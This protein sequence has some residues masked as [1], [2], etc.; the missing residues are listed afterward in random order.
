MPPSVGAKLATAPPEPA[1]N[2][3]SLTDREYDVLR[4]IALGHTNAEIAGELFLSVATVKSH[5]NA[6]FAKLPARDRAQAIAS[7]RGLLG[8]ALREGWW[9]AG[10]HLPFPGLGHVRAERGAYAWVPA[11]FSPLPPAPPAPGR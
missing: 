4:M 9:V 2:P 5:V 1:G 11:E 7:R 6:I 10:A 8:R 3:G